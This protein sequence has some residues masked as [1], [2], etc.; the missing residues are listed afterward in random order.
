MTELQESKEKTPT[1]EDRISDKIEKD[2]SQGEVDFDPDS[3]NQKFFNIKDV[4]P[5]DLKAQW[6]GNANEVLQKFDS[7]MQELKKEK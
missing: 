7:K 3:P 5:L 2:S 1:K 6:L 4:K